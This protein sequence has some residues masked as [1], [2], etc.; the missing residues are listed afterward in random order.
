MYLFS[1]VRSFR[2]ATVKIVCI[3]A[4][5]VVCYLANQNDLCMFRFIFRGLS[6]ISFLFFNYKAAGPCQMR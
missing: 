6:F 4:I 2:L 1:S 3:Y 5:R